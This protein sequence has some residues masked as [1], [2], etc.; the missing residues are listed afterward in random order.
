M[1]KSLLAL[2]ITICLVTAVM[3]APTTASANVQTGK[4]LDLLQDFV[5]NCPSRVSGTSDMQ[6]VAAYV[7]DKFIQFG[8]DNVE[9]QAIGGLQGDYNVIATINA[10]SA[11]QTVVIGAHYDTTNIEGANDN[12]CGVVALFMLADHLSQ[13]KNQLGFNVQLVAFSGEE[14]GLLGSKHFVNSLTQSQRDSIA[15][16][17]N[18]DVIASGDNLYVLCEN[19]QTPLLTTLVDLGINTPSKIYAKPFG[20]G[21][22]ALL[23]QWGYGY[24]EVAQNTDHTPFRLAGIPTAVYFSGSYKGHFYGYVES[25]D[26]SK[27]TMNSANDTLQNLLDNAP[28]FQDKVNNVVQSVATLLTNSSYNNVVSTA[29][30]HLTSNVLT[31]RLYAKLVAVAIVVLAIV[32]VILYGKKLKKQSLLGVAQVKESK[33]FTTP[34]VNDIFKF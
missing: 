16:M 26:T 34:D 22:Y 19:K 17:I 6:A 20:K 10:P 7:E 24:W 30:D 25:N 15:L 5:T 31:N 18:F 23:D 27:W 14:K 21:V 2:V 29:R 1:K 8:V 9:L 32:G 3:A 28:N 11:T 4:V 13:H 33:V 12:A